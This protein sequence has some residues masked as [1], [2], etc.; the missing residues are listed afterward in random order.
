MVSYSD[1]SH[2]FELVLSHAKSAI[3]SVRFTLFENFDGATNTDSIY[4]E[5]GAQFL[6]VP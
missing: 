1:S 3:S 6:T 4:L 2:A 5:V